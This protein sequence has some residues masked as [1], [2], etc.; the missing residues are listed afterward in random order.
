MTCFS[1]AHHISI[2]YL[3][4]K[5]S[6]G[7][8]TAII[9]FSDCTGNYKSHYYDFVLRF[10]KIFYSSYK[11]ISF[12]FPVLYTRLIMRRVRGETERLHFS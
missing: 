3:L 1:R 2:I 8:W 11:T 9:W 10:L 4:A 6:F 12:L 5:Y 7:R